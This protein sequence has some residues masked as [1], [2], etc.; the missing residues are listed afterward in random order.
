ML[1]AEHGST[2]KPNVVLDN[3]FKLYENK[4]YNKVLQLKGTS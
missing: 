4:I 3:F 2:A 1:V